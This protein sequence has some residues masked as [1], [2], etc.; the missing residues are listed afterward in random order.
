VPTYFFVTTNVIFNTTNI[1]IPFSTVRLN[2]G[3]AMDVSTGKFTAPRTGTYFFS[4]IGLIGYPTS[5]STVKELIV[6]LYLNGNDIVRSWN[7]EANTAVT[8]EV[9]IALQSTLNLQKGDQVW[10]QIKVISTGV[11]LYE[12]P[13][14]TGWLLQE[15]I[16]QSLM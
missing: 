14:F 11:I 13:A 10:L 16:T 9:P 5:S 12:V 7:D 15:N 8:Q 6:G 4:F 2:I 1:P 3:G